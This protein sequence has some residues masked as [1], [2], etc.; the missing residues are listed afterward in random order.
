[1]ENKI[2]ALEK[3]INS[4]KKQEAENYKKLNKESF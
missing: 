1:M 4:L 2:K 3:E